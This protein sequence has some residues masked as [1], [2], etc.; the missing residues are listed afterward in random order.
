MKGE[1]VTL[2]EAMRLLDC[3]RETIARYRRAGLLV[4]R[5]KGESDGFYGRKKFLFSSKSIAL[6]GLKLER[7]KRRAALNKMLA[8]YHDLRSLKRSSA[9][10]ELSRELDDGMEDAASHH[11]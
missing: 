1:W 9:I 5:R 8:A 2:A 6:L 4:V 10:K 3:C 7:R 11:D